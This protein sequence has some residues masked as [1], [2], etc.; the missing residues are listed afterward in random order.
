MLTVLPSPRRNPSPSDSPVQPNASPASCPVHVFPPSYYPMPV[1]PPPLTAKQYDLFNFGIPLRDVLTPTRMAQRVG[2]LRRTSRKLHDL[3]QRYDFSSPIYIRDA[4]DL[5]SSLR[6]TSVIHLV[7]VDL[8]ILLRYRAFYGDLTVMGWSTR[9]DDS[10]NETHRTGTLRTPPPR[11]EETTPSSVDCEITQR[12]TA[13][14]TRSD[15]P[16]LRTS[17]TSIEKE[18][19]HGEIFQC[20]KQLNFLQNSS[21]ES[22]LNLLVLTQG[23]WLE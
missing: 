6:S 12:E 22:V 9:N 13:A 17:P 18:K 10:S 19:R 21:S 23:K 15:P 14:E 3:A 16:P 20:L 7:L 2:F 4:C 11:A 1:D 5:C 8:E